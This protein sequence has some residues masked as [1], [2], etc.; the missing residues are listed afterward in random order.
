MNAMGAKRRKMEMT[1]ASPFDW[2]TMTDMTKISSITYT[3]GHR[4][5]GKGLSR[6]E[7]AKDGSK[8]HVARRRVAN[9]SI[10]L[11][12]C[13]CLVLNI[14]E[15]ERVSVG[16]IRIVDSSRCR[17][18]TTKQPEKQVT[19]NRCQ[20]VDLSSSIVDV[21]LVLLDLF[22]PRT[23]CSLFSTECVLHLFTTK[24]GSDS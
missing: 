22:R 8:L 19:E 17:Q 4:S 9:S 23:V 13:F 15:S 12:V 21:I 18:A 1:G 11:R 14:C 2:R 16:R 7:K 6:S 3:T 5:R 20:M 10:W 24:T